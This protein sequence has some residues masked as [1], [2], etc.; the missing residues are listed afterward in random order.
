MI[1]GGEGDP[2]LK[3]WDTETG[4]NINDLEGHQNGVFCI[5]PS[6]DGAFF[7]S[8]GKD[9]TLKVWDLRDQNCAFSIDCAEFGEPTSVAIN[10]ETYNAPNKI[11]AVSHTSGTI[12]LWDLNMRK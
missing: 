10:S 12:S 3:I 1:S 5:K 8:V 2:Y 9:S 4:K 6:F 7:T 11:T